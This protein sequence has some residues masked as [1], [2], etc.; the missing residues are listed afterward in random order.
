MFFNSFEILSIS[1]KKSLMIPI[2][3]ICSL[4]ISNLSFTQQRLLNN[5]VNDNVNI[6]NLIIKA[7]SANK[8]A[9]Y[10]TSLKIC[11][12]ILL[13]YKSL[14]NENLIDIYRL[15]ALNY[16]QLYEYRS[17]SVFLDS[18][19]F[20]YHKIQNKSNREYVDL[21]NI[22]SQILYDD[23]RE[24]ESII[25]VDSILSQFK[26]ESFLEI[27]ETYD[28]KGV[29]FSYNR[30]FNK[31]LIFFEKA[32]EVRLP[33][34]SEFPLEIFKSYMLKALYFREIGDPKSAIIE[35]NLALSTLK[36]YTGNYNQMINLLREMS[37]VYQD[38]NELDHALNLIFEAFGILKSN[39]TE[40]S[41]ILYAKLYC[42]L[43]NIYRL[44]NDLPNS[45]INYDKSLNLFSEQNCLYRDYAITCHNLGVAYS[46]MGKLNKADSLYDLSVKIL[47]KN[48]SVLPKS[49][50]YFLIQVYNSKSLLHFYSQNY[51][52]SIDSYRK[53]ISLIED[54]F[55]PN[56]LE[57]YQPLNNLGLCYQN[58]QNYNEA[59]RCYSDAI[60]ILE[61]RVDSSIF[62]E[63]LIYQLE[64]SYL[65]WNKAENLQSKYFSFN[66]TN[67]LLESLNYFEKYINYL[68]YLRTNLRSGTSKINLFN[69]NKIAYE[70]CIS[71]IINLDKIKYLH[72]QK[73]LNLLWKCIEES[74]SLLLLESFNNHTLKSSKGVPN[75]ITQKE[76][77]FLEQL[78]EL[79]KKLFETLPD[80]SDQ[81]YFQ[82]ELNS[83]IINLKLE[84]FNF[85]DSIKL[86]YPI[87]YNAKYNPDIIDYLE[88]KNLLKNQTILNYFVGDSSIFIFVVRPDTFDVVQVKKDFPLDSLVRQMQSGLY[89]YY[90]QSPNKRSDFVFKNSIL[91]YSKAANELYQRIMAPVAHLLTSDLVIIPDGVLGYV[92]FEALL[93]SKPEKLNQFG[94]YPFLINDHTISYN[95]SAT[96]W[97]EM[98]S[99][100][101]KKEPSKSIVAFAPFYEGSYTVLDSTINLVFD[102]LPNGRD[103]TIFQDVVSRKT[104]APLPSSGIEA[105]TVSKMWKGDFFINNDA[106]EQRFYNVA[107]EYRFIHLSTHGVADAREGDYSYLAFAEQKDSIENEF[108]YVRDIYNTSLNADLVFLSACETAQ[109]ELQRGEGIISL[110]RAFSYAGAKSIITTLWQVDDAATKDISI[111]FYKNLKKGF[112]KDVALRQAKLRHI[113]S[114]RSAQKHPFFWAAMIGIG[115]MEREK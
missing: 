30:N 15:K 46:N 14:Q 24:D 36:N 34:Q 52:L 92:P 44:M 7:Q 90:G 25:I 74:K 99:K 33:L 23:G 13:S 72:K 10:K 97:N 104:Y 55:G 96:L 67:D 9:H 80:T 3:L 41:N 5:E 40:I 59:D 26:N 50:N 11:D 21:M 89:G 47:S 20:Y 113:K 94:T 49:I 66:D 106:T 58:L 91:D 98:K 101:H 85:L 114:A 54:N 110:A 63:T 18:S 42:D 71:L 82:D 60:K 17:A 81:V 37:L 83:S 115:D 108:L 16:W 8:K 35:Y 4:I 105:G 28:Q 12:T 22:K 69:D 68:R 109:G 29:Y 102:T 100:K 111:D 70:K 31:A 53:L 1:A 93:K 103:T 56:A 45:I 87:Y 48:Y 43:G 2:T 65:I 64:W 61:S 79:N 39:E 38:F 112:P 51:L 77:I 73:Y 6:R 78:V 88:F 107:G 75:E 84:F 32:K 19:L 86:N 57:L 27:A 76:G 95:Y 62:Y